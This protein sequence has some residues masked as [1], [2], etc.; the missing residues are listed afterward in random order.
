MYEY[1]RQYFQNNQS[2][3]IQ[4]NKK[5]RQSFRPENKLVAGKVR[6]VPNYSQFRN[7][8]PQKAIIHGID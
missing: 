8:R 3:S 7:L 6:T 2:I 4:S 5:L 1:R